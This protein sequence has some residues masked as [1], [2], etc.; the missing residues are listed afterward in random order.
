MLAY[1]EEQLP[2]QRIADLYAF[3]RTKPPV[4]EPG[5]WHW[6]PAP[7]TAPLGQQLYMQTA[8]CGQCHEPENGMG[9]A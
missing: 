5:E 1:T 4:Q 8:G 6:R 9:R 7:E 2:D 3:L